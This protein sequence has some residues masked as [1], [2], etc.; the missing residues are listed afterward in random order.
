MIFITSHPE[1]VH[2][3]EMTASAIAYSPLFLVAYATMFV[4]MM[5]MIAV[6]AA[7]AAR[8]YEIKVDGGM[9]RV[10]EVFA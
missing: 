8:A 4:F 7:A 3:P 10:A 6:I 9:T 2:S 5:V 1:L